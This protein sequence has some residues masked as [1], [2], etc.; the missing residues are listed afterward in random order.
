MTASSPEHFTHTHSAMP[1]SSL[2]TVVI[3]TETTGLDVTQARIIEFGAVRMS[4]SEIN[5]KDVFTELVNPET[6]IPQKAQNV[7]GITNSDVKDA[8]TFETV[9]GR[10]QKWLGDTVIVGYAIGFDISILHAECHRNNYPL[11]SYQTLDV[12][13]L[14]QILQP[15]LPDYSLELIAAWLGLE[16]ANRHR[17]LGDARLTAE[18]YACLIPKLKAKGIFTLLDVD[19]VIQKLTQ[20]H[21]GEARAGWINRSSTAPIK[22]FA[23]VDSYPYR[24]RVADVM[25]TPPAVKS[26]KT[27]TKTIL[28]QM[29]KNSISSIFVKL[30]DKFGII[31]ERDILRAIYKNGSKAL[32]SPAR[33]YA[34]FP[35]QTVQQDEF[36]YRALLTMHNSNIR[37]LG[38]TDAGG[39][40]VGALTPRNLLGQRAEDAVSLGH[41]ID[42]AETAVE[43]GKIWPDLVMVART[44]AEEDVDARDIAAIISRELQNLTRRACEIVESQML[45]EGKGPPPQPYAMLVLG[46]GGR[47]ESLLAMDQDNA[48]IFENGNAESPVDQ[49]LAELGARV[50]DILDSVG[51]SYCKGSIMGG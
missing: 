3:D 43:L 2:S 21:D 19:R 10:F 12:R 13:H 39:H 11:P 41:Q 32:N 7:H 42:A 15:N 45:S 48:I 50:S 6:P 38:V 31:T 30:D 8:K 5:D 18:I 20:P 17:A 51:V 26:A 44:L 22:E 28:E 46:S 37:H 34:S 4:G 9:F 14:T 23:R 24:H 1:L 49:W 33:E 40:L 27:K 16:V 25:Q 29:M 47:G 36:V 35:L